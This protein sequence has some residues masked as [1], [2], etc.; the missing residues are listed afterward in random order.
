MI[1]NDFHFVEDG[2]IDFDEFKDLMEKN[3]KD[4]EEVKAE[5]LRAFKTFDHNSKLKGI[6]I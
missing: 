5:L 1:I 6:I 4:S 2:V 3:L